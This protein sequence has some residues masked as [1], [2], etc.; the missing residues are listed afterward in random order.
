MDATAVV[1]V[2][3]STG[4]GKSQL[5]IN[6]ASYCRAQGQ[7]AEIISADSMQTYHGLDVITNKAGTE[8]MQGIPHHLMS[9]MEPGDEYDITQFVEDATKLVG[10]GTHQCTSMQATRTLPVLV[11]GTT[12]Y[13][14][15]LLF[16]G[17]LVSAAAAPV[18]QGER[19]DIT[20]LSLDQLALWD[21]LEAPA[22]AD[23]EPMALWTLLQTLDPDSAQRWHPR[24]HRKVYR[25]LCI[26][27]ETGTRQSEWVHAQDA[28]AAGAP[29]TPPFAKR[30]L[31]LWVWCER[32]VLRERLDV[33]IGKMLERGLLDEIRALRAIAQKGA[34]PVD[35][36][37]GIYQAIGTCTKLIQGT[38]SLMHTF[39]T[40][41]R[42]ATRHAQ[43]SCCTTPSQPC[44]WRQGATR[45][46]K[47]HGYATS[48]C[49]RSTRHRRRAKKCMCMCWMPPIW[50]RGTPRCAALPSS[51]YKVRRRDSPSLSRG[52]AA[53]AAG[54]RRTRRRRARATR[55]AYAG[56]RGA[57]PDVYVRHMH[58]RPP[59]SVPDQG[60]RARKARTV[61]DAS[62][63]RTPPHTVHMDCR[64]EGAWRREAARASSTAHCAR[65]VTARAPTPLKNMVR[66]YRRSAIGRYTA[67]SA[68]VGTILAMN[69]RKRT[70]YSSTCT[71][72]GSA[73]CK[74]RSPGGGKGT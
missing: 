21:A 16:S 51:L 50:A 14:Q 60:E 54:R 13:I 72:F 69:L 67:S 31:F 26:L 66:A 33:R 64:G 58:K 53:A 57:Q 24:D 37:R 68:I 12:Y 27:K 25:S 35:Y 4:T 7:P 49:P 62:R 61:T 19:V 43:I 74:L 44:R 29:S 38:R 63:V 15:H 56:R 42:A 10:R 73:C 40:A 22:T 52:T 46:A 70:R 18:P 32:S 23:A 2:V 45:S 59:A 71:S 20:G 41:K 3:G 9:F 28:H 39:R 8:E 17:R 30:R 11:G 55:R 36:T 65:R 1:V 48:S 47:P 5:G 6:I 34:G